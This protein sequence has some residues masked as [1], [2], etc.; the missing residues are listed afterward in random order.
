M[1]EET[2]QIKETEETGEAE[3]G[4][5]GLS[6]HGLA[7]PR[8]VV[9]P[10]R[11]F[12]EPFSFSELS[13]EA[14]CNQFLVRRDVQWE[15]RRSAPLEVVFLVSSS[16]VRFAA[17]FFDDV[18]VLVVVVVVRL[19]FLFHVTSFWSSAQNWATDEASRGQGLPC[20]RMVLRN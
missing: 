10:L 18:T 14:L 17:A 9:T 19:P 3:K 16:P 4:K 12:S 5:A 6:R 20:A 8:P 1:D 7:V 11:P 2:E 15:C 13:R